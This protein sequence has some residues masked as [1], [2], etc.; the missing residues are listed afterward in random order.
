[1]VL[2]LH[3]KANILTKGGVYTL[4]QNKRKK[5]KDENF[6]IVKGIVDKVR[7]FKDMNNENIIYV[8]FLFDNHYEFHEI[9]SARF[10]AVLNQQF[11]EEVEDEYACKDFSR[12]L[13]V[14]KEET[15]LHGDSVKPY[16]RI[17]GNKKHIVYFLA[18]YDWNSVVVTAK[19]WKIRQQEKYMFVKK[20]NTK[21]QVKPVTYSG[22]IDDLLRVL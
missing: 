7:F 20:A 18:D 2:T 8:Q 22:N 17:A 10:K 12:V 3:H 11:R 13:R 9:K 6:E 4:G 14:K 19:G 16:T 1:M 5:E 15:I 21:E